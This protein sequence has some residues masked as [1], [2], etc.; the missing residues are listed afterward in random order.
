MFAV[1]PQVKFLNHSSL[2]ISDGATS[3]LCDP[4]FKGAAFDSGW[5]LILEESH[6]IAALEFDYIW[7]SHEHPDHFSPLTLAGL[8][9]TTTFLYQKT[10]D[11]K[12]VAYLRSK[13]HRVVELEDGQEIQLGQMSCTLFF[14]DGYDSVL[15]TRF[16]DGSTF[17]NVND[18]RLELGDVIKK[19]LAR[20]KKLDSMAIQFSYANWAG[21]DG[22][23]VMAMDQHKLVLDRIRLVG[24]LLNPRQIILFAAFVYFS[25]EE[26]FYWNKT[27]WLEPTVMALT[28]DMSCDIVVP[29]PERIIL[30]N[31]AVSSEQ[32]TSN[33]EAI[34]FWTE[35]HKKLV[36]KDFS[37]VP[38]SI[39]E[40]EESYNQFYDRLWKAN[41][42]DLAAQMAPADF[43]LIVYL[44]DLSRVVEIG[45]ITRRFS[46]DQRQTPDVHVSS[47]TLDFLFQK[48]FGRGTISINSKIQFNYPSAH[49]FFIFFFIYYA[50][51]IGRF[52]QSG[53]LSW[54]DLETLNKLSVL[55]SIFRLHPEAESEFS[56]CL[57][58]FVG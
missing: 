29:I 42:H 54:N 34:Q 26:N 2:I 24:G 17:L 1:K 7:I 39:S 46:T 57:Q 3:I 33:S 21:N 31:D 27:F 22:D 44:T 50:N 18:A 35:Q 58:S 4:W 38:L 19:I 14:C 32:S 55:R 47:R 13:G 56:R 45:L 52:F 53:E 11:G 43:T 16:S 41:D 48:E 6:D 36:P 49:K 51:N 8:K 25:H 5:R 10:R 37:G 23:S 12:V 30:V 28:Q 40:L 15:F 20:C 9:K